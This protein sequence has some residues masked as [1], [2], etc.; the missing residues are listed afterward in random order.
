[1]IECDD[2][3][4]IRDDNVSG[5]EVSEMFKKFTTGL[6]TGTLLLNLV[7][8]ALADVTIDV[9]GNGTGSDNYVKVKEKCIQKVKQSNYTNANINLNLS[10]NTGGNNAN[11]NTGGTQTI[12]TG[13]VNNTANVTVTGGDNTAV[14]ADC[15]CG[16]EGNTQANVTVSDNGSN[17][18]NTVR[19]KKVKKQKVKQ[20]TRTSA[21]VVGTLVGTTG[22]NDAN[23]NTGSGTDVDTGNVTNDA[24]VDV[25]GGSNSL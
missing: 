3:H 16:E 1:M 9:I 15:C 22:T 19:V 2:S 20:R 24:T 10:G 11:D 18:T 25:A 5:L 7:V 6:A 4:F 14:V 13:N 8:P 21:T 23:D 17:T 12:S